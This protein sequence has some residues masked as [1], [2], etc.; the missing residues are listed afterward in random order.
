MHAFLARPFVTRLTA[1]ATVFGLALPA[2]SKALEQ[3]NA[4][5]ELGCSYVAEFY[6]RH[7]DSEAFSGAFH[8]HHGRFHDVL[9]L[10]ALAD[11]EAED[12]NF[13]ADVLDY[14]HHRRARIGPTMEYFGPYTSQFAWRMYRAIDWTHMH[15][16]QTYS[17]LSDRRI[18]WRD[19][20]AFTDRAVR[21]YVEKNAGVARSI[22]PLDVTMRRAAVMMK[23]YFTVSRNAYPRSTLL[24]MAAHWWHPAI[25]EAMMISGNDE[26]QDR[27]VAETNRVL[28]ERVLVDRPTR[29]LLSREIMPRYSRMSPESANVFDNL[30]MLHGISFD[31]LAYEGWTPAQKQAEIYRF[32]DAMSYQPGD[33]RLVR[34]FET[35]HPDT[36]PRSYEPWM[37]GF[38]GDMNRIMIEM[39]NEMML[40]MMPGGTS[41]EMRERMMKHLRM[42]LTPGMQP[43]EIPGSL[44]DAMMKIMPEMKMSPGSMEPGRSSK[45][46]V[47]AMLR[48]WR[49]K[50]GDLQDVEPWPMAEDPSA[51]AMASA[52]AARVEG[53]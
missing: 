32:I 35:P 39:M 49:E 21:Y 44:H 23:P 41:P 1:V 31:I 36:D 46:M 24:A 33:E 29:M 17:I 27:V 40:L 34:K 25:Y 8:F 20:K 28:F 7:P 43:G 30:H 52:R 13:D 37:K 53:R 11:A 9:S 12:R 22:A 5:F 10:S 2:P 3:R 15:H 48:G 42:K 16:E 51:P 4:V 26:E 45:Q 18:P 19:K 47:D 50:S 14:L 6:E 38:E